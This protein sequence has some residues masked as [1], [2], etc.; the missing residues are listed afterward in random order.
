MDGKTAHSM[1]HDVE[2]NGISDPS[3]HQEQPQESQWLESG[4]TI[5]KFADEN[6]DLNPLQW[7]I[8]EKSVC[9]S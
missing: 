1:P 7:K 5:V 6:D 3:K 9:S 8:T 4:T 2:K